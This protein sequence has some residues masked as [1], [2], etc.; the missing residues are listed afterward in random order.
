MRQIGTIVTILVFVSI[1]ATLFIAL[2]VVLSALD[3]RHLQ[4]IAQSL[5]FQLLAVICFQA[6]RTDTINFEVYR[7]DPL[8][9]HAP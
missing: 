1:A 7:A 2:A 6:D 9:N 5:Y 3:L 4:P 8:V